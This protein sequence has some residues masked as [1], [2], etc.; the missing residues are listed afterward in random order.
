MT[1]VGEHLAFGRAAL[2]AKI[3]E[4]AEGPLERRMEVIAG[5][6][7]RRTRTLIDDVHFEQLAETSHQ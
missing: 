1:D 5:T 2:I 3:D 4:D 7:L 6:P